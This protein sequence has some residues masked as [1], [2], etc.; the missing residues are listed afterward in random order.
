MKGGKGIRQ[1]CEREGKLSERERERLT[2]ESE[3][4]SAR[5]QRSVC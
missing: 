1:I 5:R 4:C 2:V 3:I